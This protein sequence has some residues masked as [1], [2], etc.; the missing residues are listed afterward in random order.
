MLSAFGWLVQARL[1]ID[2]VT[3]TDDDIVLDMANI[4]R[5]FGGTIEDNI[6]CG[7]KLGNQYPPQRDKKSRW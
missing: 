6:Y 1:P 4:E 5:F 2:L 7:Y 3:V